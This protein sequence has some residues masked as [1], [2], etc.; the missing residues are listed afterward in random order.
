MVE[1]CELFNYADDNTLSTSNRVINHLIQNLLTDTNIII[2]WFHQNFMKVNPDKFQ[3][4]IMKPTGKNDVLPHEIQIEGIQIK[5]S[6][7]VRLLGIDIDCNLNFYD[8][9]KKSYASKPIGS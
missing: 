3:L 9:V 1:V 8:H 5:A 2:Q 4:M 6:K 7:S